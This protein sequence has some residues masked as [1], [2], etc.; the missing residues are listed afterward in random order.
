M[1]FVGNELLVEYFIF[2]FEDV[3]GNVFNF[4]KEVVEGEVEVVSEVEVGCLGGRGLC[5]SFQNGRDICVV[6]K[7]V[8]V[9]EKV[10]IVIGGGDGGD[11]GY[12]ESGSSGEELEFYVDG[13]K[14]ESKVVDCC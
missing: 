6:F 5:V 2:F 3:V 1:V 4:G 14:F 7:V 10:M 9:R 13:W 11:S 12:K 8:G